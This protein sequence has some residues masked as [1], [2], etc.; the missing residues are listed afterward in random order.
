MK[1]SGSARGFWLIRKGERWMVRRRRR[2]RTLEPETGPTTGPTGGVK[3]KT[4]AG[5][6]SE[7][8]CSRARRVSERRH[9][10][11]IPIPI[12]R[13]TREATTGSLRLS[14]TTLLIM[15]HEDGDDEIPFARRARAREAGRRFMGGKKDGV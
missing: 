9:P 14:S 1:S 12:R 11:S 3:R 6:L 4:L 15:E 5:M 8:L 7:A 13:R 2:R 10:G